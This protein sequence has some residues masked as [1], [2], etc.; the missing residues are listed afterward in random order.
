VLKNSVLRKILGPKWE[1]VRW[2][3]RKLHNE[4]LHDLNFS[5]NSI[6]MI[7]SKRIMRW[8]G[9]VTSRRERTG[10][11]K[12]LVWQSEGT[13]RLENLCTY[14]RITLKRVLKKYD[15]WMYTGLF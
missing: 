3:W 2:D 15:Q 5:L 13:K 14:G 1:E 12:V 8:V 6:W 11:Y 4:K 10:A 7:E 9:D